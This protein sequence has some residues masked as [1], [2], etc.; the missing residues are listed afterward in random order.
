M[1]SVGQE[2]VRVR[3]PLHREDVTSGS[4]LQSAR[5][6]TAVRMIPC[7]ADVH[8]GTIQPALV[9]VGKVIPSGVQHREIRPLPG[10]VNQADVPKP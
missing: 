1:A 5:L 7:H 9:L 8:G 3:P 2:P 6:S 10:W 4:S